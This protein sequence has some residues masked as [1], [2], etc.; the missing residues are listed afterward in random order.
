M[1]LFDSITDSHTTLVIDTPSQ[2]P[3]E[4]PLS[5]IDAPNEVTIYRT[6]DGRWVYRLAHHNPLPCVIAS[7]DHRE[8]IKYML[9]GEK[10]Y[11]QAEG[12][13]VRTAFES[14]FIPE[15][16]V[17]LH[18]ACV[19]KDGVAVAF[20]GVSGMGKSTR[21]RAW[22]ESLGA[23][24]ISG[25]RPAVRMEEN[26][27]TACGVPWDGKE[28][29]FRNVERPLKAI[30]DVRRA[31]ETY[32]CRLSHEQARRLLMRQTFVPMWNAALAFMA[33]AN[34][35]QLIAKT[36]IYR[37][38]CGPDGEAARQVCNILYRHPE[39][40]REEAEEMKIKEGFA[41]RNVLDEHVVMP[42]GDK[43]AK[44]EGAVVLNEVSAFVWEKLQHPISREDLLNAILIEFDVPRK[45][46]DDDLDRL[47][48]RFSEYGLLEEEHA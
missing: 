43:I 38:F 34:L 47:L 10:H 7:A 18:A 20:T 21:A 45:V 35:H 39:S 14:R 25:D 27:S 4:E 2:L 36:P 17:S 31:S 22:V 33:M 41:L 40:I 5:L 24:W 44:F 16:I 23:E 12:F 28:Q 8:I 32:I 42:V 37:V 3:L 30:M 13:L 19:E 48:M 9:A 15:G 6:A 29:I 26:G 11:N 1:T 46:A